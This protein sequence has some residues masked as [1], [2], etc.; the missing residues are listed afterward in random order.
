MS[1]KAKFEKLLRWYLN[2]TMR[3][4]DKEEFDTPSKEE[5]KWLNQM[6]YEHSEWTESV[7]PE[8]GLSKDIFFKK[9]VYY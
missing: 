2:E 5:L 1:E 4:S 7:V 6:A 8:F 9:I 3:G